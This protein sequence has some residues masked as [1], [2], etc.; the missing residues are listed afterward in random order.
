MDTRI[1]E[2]QALWNS[3]SEEQQFAVREGRLLEGMP[4]EAVYL[5]FGSPQYKREGFE[6]GVAYEEWIF[7]R[8]RNREIMDWRYRQVSRRGDIFFEP[9]YG[10]VRV[11]DEYPTRVVRIIDGKVAA[12]SALAR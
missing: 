5:A 3:L 7:T 4:A 6:N 8:L 12:W 9:E 11:Y 10:P 1:E 2:N